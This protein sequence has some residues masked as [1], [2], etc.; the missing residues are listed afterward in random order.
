M[1]RRWFWLRPKWVV[2]H[3]LCL[4]LIVLFVRL[5]FW[6]LSRLHQKEA[7][8]ELV[9]TR[10]HDVPE[11]LDQV[12]AGDPSP[13]QVAYRRV[14]ASGTWHPAQTLLVRSRTLDG[15]P[16]YYV[17]T[18]LDLGEGRGI[19]V[20]RGF[21]PSGG[22][23]EPALRRA[24]EVPAAP[25]RVEGI[26]RPQEEKTHFGAAD[27]ATGTLTVLNRIDVRRIQQQT[28]SL[29]L[30]TSALQLTAPAPRS[31][32]VPELL[33][34][35]ATDLGPHKSYAFQ[36]FSFAAVGAIGWPLL[37]RRTGRDEA[38]ANAHPEE[39]GDSS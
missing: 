32:G 20:N 25:A 35:P 4:T 6:Q 36:W 23:G 18:V 7:R 3:V 2:G 12:L 26:L 9:T 1:T 17:L 37:L 30:V 28:P 22:G 31:G 13:A 21:A 8:R 34:L 33:P 16:G 11:P 14:T 10:M 5:G 38:R 27:P 29:R 39:A 19:V 24:V 15:R